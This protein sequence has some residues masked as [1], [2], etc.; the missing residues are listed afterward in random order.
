MPISTIIIL[1]IT[2]VSLAGCLVYSV[3]NNKDQ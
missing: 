1:G 3:I 2:F